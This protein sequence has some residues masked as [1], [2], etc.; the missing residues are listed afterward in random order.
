MLGD[1]HKTVL[2]LTRFALF[3]FD[4]A[5]QLRADETFAG[6]VRNNLMSKEI[7]QTHFQ[8]QLRI[9]ELLGLHWKRS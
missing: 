2:K 7:G 1:C 8:C 5:L 4:N 9:E 6:Q 3:Q